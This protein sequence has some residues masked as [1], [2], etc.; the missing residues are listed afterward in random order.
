MW[1]LLV[2]SMWP[3]KKN[4]GAYF[5][6]SAIL[7]VWHWNKTFIWSWVTLNGYPV[8]SIHSHIHW[9]EICWK[10]PCGTILK[11]VIFQVFDVEILSLYDHE[12]HQTSF[13]LYVFILTSIEYLLISHKTTRVVKSCPPC[14][15]M[16]FKI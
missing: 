4:S 14:M 2:N 16:S 3:C 6:I 1:N 11:L 13:Q 9:Y 5:A 10:T 8:I 15:F 12:W 7:T